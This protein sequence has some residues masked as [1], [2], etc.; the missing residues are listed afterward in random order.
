MCPTSIQVAASL[1]PVSGYIPE[2]HLVF[3]LVPAHCTLHR[4][5]LLLQ[6]SVLWYAC[7]RRFSCPPDYTLARLIPLQAEYP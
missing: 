1:L 5:R 7:S 3:P 4:L 6:S 2:R